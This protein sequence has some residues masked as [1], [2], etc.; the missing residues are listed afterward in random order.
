L[1]ERLDTPAKNW[2][3]DPS[4]IVARSKWDEYFKAY[5][6]VFAKTSHSHAPW[7]IIPANKKWARNLLVARIV[8]ATMEDLKLSYPKVNYDPSKV[9]ID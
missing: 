7:Y 2:K 9:E 3:F 1:Q 4:D 8:V 6:D 5:E